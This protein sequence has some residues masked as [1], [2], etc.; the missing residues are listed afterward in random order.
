MSR[1][2]AS[3]AE[4]SVVARNQGRRQNAAETRRR[5]G[6][7]P[8]PAR[9]ARFGSYLPPGLGPGLLP[10][11]VV[12]AVVVAV[13]AVGDRRLPE[14]DLVE[15]RRRSIGVVLL[16]RA[17]ALLVHLRA[18]LRVRGRLAEV[19]RLLRLHLRRGHV[20]HPQVGAVDVL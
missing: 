14:L 15:V 8:P 2:H 9:Y 7:R 4:S 5:A 1:N 13:A 12:H 16:A 11:V 10:L 17:R 6:S 20:L 3:G 18:S 19:D